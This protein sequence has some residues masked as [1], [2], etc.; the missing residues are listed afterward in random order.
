MEGLF[1]NGLTDRQASVLAHFVKNLGLKTDTMHYFKTEQ[2][3]EDKSS[4]DVVVFEPTDEFEYYLITTTGLSAYQF[5]QDFA[6]AELFMLLPPSWKM[7]FEKAEY[8]WPVYFLQ[9]IAY[10]IIENKMFV[11]PY[12]VYRSSEK[13][14]LAGT[15]TV[16]GVVV[17]P[18]MLNIEILEEKIFDTYTRFFQLMP[19]NKQELAKVD[20]IG[21]KDYVDFDL[22]DADGPK[23]VVKEPMI[24]KGATAIDKI[25]E[26]NENSLKGK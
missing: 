19:L 25:I 4:I 3:L 16:G 7:D 5:S 8:A 17:F 14:Y 15:D 1:V 26:H 9:D 11:F 24:K 12:Q 10:N 6:P 18:E 21:V 22:H 20:D 23:L 2:F 13:K